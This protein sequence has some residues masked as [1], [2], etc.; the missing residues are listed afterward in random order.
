[1]TTD[2]ERLRARLRIGWVAVLAAAGCDPAGSGAGDGKAAP[3]AV[4]R[5]AEL[6]ARR[7]E[8]RKLEAV[9][10]AEKAKADAEAAK[11]AE[12]K[13]IADAE[14]ATAAD[15]KAKEMELALAAQAEAARAAE[16]AA[17]AGNKQPPKLEPTKPPNLRMPSCP[18]GEWS[19]PA[20]L[21]KKL[22][23][24]SGTTDGC[25]RF[26]HHDMAKQAAEDSKALNGLPN[27]ASGTL[28]VTATKKAG[29]GNCVYH[30]VVACPGGRVLI[31][32]GDVVLAE[33]RE[34]EAWGGVAGADDD[35]SAGALADGWLLD[36]R[37]EH[38]SIAS[39][40]RATLELLALGAPP[41]LVIGAQQ[42]S[43]DE[44]EHA[45]VCFALA[46]RYA[47]RA[48][49]PGPLA[50]ATPRA[51]DLVR[52]ACDTLV[53]GCVGET[54]AALAALRARRGCEDEV[55]AAALERIA[56]D[57]ARHAALAWATVGWAARVGGAEVRDAVVALARAMRDAALAA[58]APAADDDAAALARHG[59]L[60][61]AGQHACAVDAWQTL[62]PGALRE[63][64]GDAALA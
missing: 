60:D 10:L 63:V 58:D 35:V 30:W 28:D 6:A 1:M 36:A 55:V 46:S 47:G 29:A 45:R 62:I 22:T 3:A 14:A 48:V 8:D 21:A 51:A 40:A 54:I 13:A 34:D 49:G 25:P 15:A 57:E 9:A 56:D 38:A 32:A 52:L 64:L 11:A 16:A 17:K 19:G 20:A 4:D 44:V 33:V 39:F 23:K 43:L 61:P 27:R 41:A 42:A 5:E 12:A 50:A 26:I 59:R 7:V 18:S 53:E 24:G 31:D 2:I 37:T